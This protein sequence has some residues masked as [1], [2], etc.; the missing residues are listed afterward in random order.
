MD[1]DCSLRDVHR[2]HREIDG[3]N[4]QFGGEKMRYNFLHRSE[5]LPHAVVTC[6]ENARRIASSPQED[7]G[8]LAIE[9]RL[10]SMTL[11]EYVQHAPVNG[12]ILV[13]HGRAVA[14]VGQQGVHFPGI[15]PT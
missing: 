6:G 1:E 9:S 10:G 12:V 11:D 14:D 5:F 13:H 8:R 2:F 15:S 4:W 7:L 3:L